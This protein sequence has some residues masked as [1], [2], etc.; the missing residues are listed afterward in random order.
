MSL[1]ADYI[2]EIDCGR[3]IIESNDYFVAYFIHPH[4]ECYIE[5]MYIIPEKRKSGLCFEIL[6]SIEEI[7]KSN[8][9]KILSH[10]IVKTHKNK[11]HVEGASVAF[12]FKFHSETETE[13]N[14][15]KEL[16]E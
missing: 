4:G 1:Y 13:K 5:D 10:A 7:A 2:N 16:Y 3:K 6:R 11:D 9:C 8:N 14:F 12:G 15:I